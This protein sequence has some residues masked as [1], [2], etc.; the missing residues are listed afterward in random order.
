RP[1]H[2]AAYAR[3]VRRPGQMQA[4]AGLGTASLRPL[5]LI[6]TLSA[7]TSTL[8]AVTQVAPTPF[9]VLVYTFAPLIAALHWLRADARLRRVQLVH[10]MGFLLFIVWPVVIPWYTIKTRGRHSWP[11]ALLI[12]AAIASQLIAAI[13][14]GVALAISEQVH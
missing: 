9:V 14:V 6:A 2:H 3:F 13:L 7:F 11:L 10:D 1:P 4:P 5:F 12:L 8:Y